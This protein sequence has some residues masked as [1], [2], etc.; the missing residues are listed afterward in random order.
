[1]RGSR[2]FIL[3]LVYL[4]M[5]FVPTVRAATITVTTTADENNSNPAACSLREAVASAN[6]DT[7]IGGCAAGSGADTIDLPGGTYELT[8]N[9]Q[10]TI[11][12]DITIQRTSGTAIIEADS[13][14]FNNL[15]TWRVFNVA[16]GG[17]LSLVNLTVRHGR[18]PLLS[19]DP[20]Q[21][22]L[23]SGGCIRVVSGGVLI[24]SG[25]TVTSCGAF[26]AG[27]G[28]YGEAGSSVSISGGALTSNRAGDDGGGIRMEGG[29]LSI[30]GTTISGNQ[31]IDN[32]GVTDAAHGGG[33][34]YTGTS[35][36]IS[37]AAITG[38][39]ATDQQSSGL[40]PFRRGI[41]GGVYAQISFGFTATI[42]D[43][44]I[45][46][47]TATGSDLSA[48]GGIYK[49]SSGAL[50][51]TN[52]SIDNNTSGISAPNMSLGGG[53]Y[54]GA[55]SVTATSTTF[56]NNTASDS[57]GG[58]YNAS[59]TTNI[60]VSFIQSNF[61]STGGVGSAYYSAGGTNVV[62]DS[63]IVNNPYTSV[64]DSGGS[65]MNATDNW[66][67]DPSGAYSTMNTGSFGDSVS[68]DGSTP[69]NAGSHKTTAPDGCMVCM[70]PSGISIPRYC[71]LPPI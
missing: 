50:S 57:G 12:T 47:N 59:A 17:S 67:G 23:S 37:D 25:T 44:T 18:I 35:L 40:S 41:G 3:G 20:A 63:C 49:D 29:S 26:F 6:G 60:T 34:S 11:T 70:G 16:S 43:T 36:T 8:T 52:S 22:S 62:I 39:T 4:A 14:A 66:W 51:I 2:W 28:I 7:G 24:L 53:L 65:V 31:T 33:V 58:I 42:S 48:G 9:T 15:V 27:G 61:V 5:M 13:V 1:M 21:A 38:N 30:G 68:G 71:E 10:L 19:L 32:F 45:S 54:I 46:G 55:G 56:E 64:Y 69:E